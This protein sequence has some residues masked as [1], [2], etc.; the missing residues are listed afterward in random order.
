[1]VRIFS[2]EED[3]LR[4][5]DDG[6]VFNKNIVSRPLGIEHGRAPGNMFR[7]FIIKSPANTGT[8]TRRP[9]RNWFWR[10]IF[11]GKPWKAM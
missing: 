9:S 10:N 2:A 6:I 1:M 7:R 4:A 11:T 5:L 8:V 3:C